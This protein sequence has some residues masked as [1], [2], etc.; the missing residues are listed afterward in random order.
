LR[1][2]LQRG[3]AVNPRASLVNVKFDDEEDVSYILRL[4]RDLKR[5]AKK[6]KIRLISTASS[7]TFEVLIDILKKRLSSEGIDYKERVI[8][9][10]GRKIIE[11]TLNE[12]LGL[13][14][15]TGIAIAWLSIGLATGFLLAFIISGLSLEV[16]ANIIASIVA[17]VIFIFM[18]SLPEIYRKWK[19]RQRR[20]L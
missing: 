14:Y 18:F 4:A 5:D 3:G 8:S 2:Y 7:D 15:G 6:V 20:R 17:E 9:K 12:D 11:I 16:M 19:V 13:S 10:K 1:G